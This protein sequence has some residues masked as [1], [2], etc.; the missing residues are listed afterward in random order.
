M[1]DQVLTIEQM[2]PLKI[3]KCPYCKS[4]NYEVGF[5]FQTGTTASVATVKV[6]SGLILIE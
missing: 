3:C 6:C 5:F 1:K 4:Y 2:Q